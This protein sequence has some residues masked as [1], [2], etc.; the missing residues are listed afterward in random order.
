MES[1]WEKLRHYREIWLVD[2]KFIAAPGERPVPVC[3]VAHELRADRTIRLWQDDFRE[4]APYSL[5]ADSLF[6]AYF[7][8]YELG[9][10]LALGWD[11]PSRILDLYA[12]FRNLTNGLEL[13]DSSLLG[14]LTYFGLDSMGAFREAGD[15]RSCASRWYVVPGRAYRYP[16]VLRSRCTG[17]GSAFQNNVTKN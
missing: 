3:L 11:Q 17:F 16:G 8:G 13:S 2:F 15:A 14:A 10:H 6:V 1:L 9:C 12:E 4:K 7:A 5:G